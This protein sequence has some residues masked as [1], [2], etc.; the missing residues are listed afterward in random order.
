VVG[1]GAVC[2]GRK[3]VDAGLDQVSPDDTTLVRQIGITPVN[4]RRGTEHGSRLGNLR[5]V[6]EQSFALPHWFRRLRIR[7]EISAS[8]STKHS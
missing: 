2:A 5:W 7:W 3:E 8:T 4:A 6:I 1:P